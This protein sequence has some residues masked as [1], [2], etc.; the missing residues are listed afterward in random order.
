MMKWRLLPLSAAAL[1]GSTVL[2]CAG[3]CSD[4]VASMQ[5]HVDARLDAIAGAGRAAVESGAALMHRQPTP[6]SIA[7]AEEKLGELSPEKI[8]TVRAAMT[9]AREADAAGDKAACER[10]LAEAQALIGR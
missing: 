8:S 7:T 3:V 4:A 9:R 1:A 2:A 10:A 6:G 5:A